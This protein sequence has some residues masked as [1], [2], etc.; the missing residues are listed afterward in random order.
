[1]K[2][3]TARAVT[4]TRSVSRSGRTATTPQTTTNANASSAAPSA[5]AG[6][7]PKISKPVGQLAPPATGLAMTVS[8]I[9]VPAFAIPL[10]SSW[11][12][13]HGL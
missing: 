13:A 2:N 5:T 1:M 12:R 10:P 6:M 9:H 8:Q 4:P 7:N 11:A 3:A